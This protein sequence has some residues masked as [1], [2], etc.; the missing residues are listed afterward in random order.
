M[1]VI[2]LVYNY[3]HAKYLKVCVRYIIIVCVGVVDLVLVVFLVV[4]SVHVWDKFNVYV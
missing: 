2:N 4:N 1:Y 3:F